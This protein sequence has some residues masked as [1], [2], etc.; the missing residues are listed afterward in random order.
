MLRQAHGRAVRGLSCALLR[1][2][3]WSWLWLQADAEKAGGAP[4]PLTI[5]FVERKARCDEVAEAL[6]QDNIPAAALHG[7]L[8]QVRLRRGRRGWGW[9]WG[10]GAPRATWALQGRA[11]Q[12]RVRVRR[13]LLCT[14]GCCAVRWLASGAPCAAVPLPWCDVM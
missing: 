11:G 6:R 4:M 2:R 10:W 13:H 8:G 9:G 14:A 3:S 1:G 7:G 12:A 5:V